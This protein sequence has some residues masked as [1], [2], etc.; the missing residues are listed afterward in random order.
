MFTLTPRS[1]FTPAYDHAYFE[2]LYAHHADPWSVLTSHYEREKFEATVHALTKPVYEHALEVGCSIGGLT[3]YLA[4]R[5][6]ALTA[7]DT[8]GIA[9]RRA[10]EWCRQPHVR[11]VQGHLPDVDIAGPFDLIV[12]SEVLYYFTVPAL[13]R[14]GKRLTHAASPGAEV[15]VVH[16]T[17]K[18]DYPLSG[19]RV[20]DLFPSML[21]AT[22]RGCILHSQYRLE[23]WTLERENL[24]TDS[25]K[26]AAR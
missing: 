11:F 10:R 21:H 8:S 5:C 2:Q 20:M 12:L 15:I 17:G 18:T 26:D 9:I 19:D 24:S 13:I 7:I 22:V 23:I 16:W 14:L 3:Q 25:D 6:K 4:P 1:S